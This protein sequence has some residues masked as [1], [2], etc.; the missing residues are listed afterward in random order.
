MSGSSLDGLDMAVIDIKESGYQL[1]HT[2]TTPLSTDITERLKAYNS[3]SPLEYIKLEKDFSKS[4]AQSIITFLAPLDYH[5]SLIGVHGH[6]IV[7][8]PNE[9]LTIQLGN[10]GI[11]SAMTGIDTITDFR[12]QD[13]T[14]GGEG[15]PLVSI[16]DINLFSGYDYYLNLGGIANITCTTNGNLIAYDIC[17]CN[18]VLNHLSKKYYDLPYDD[19]GKIARSGKLI[20]D[21]IKEIDSFDYWNKK[22]PKSLDNNWI[23]QEF[24]ANVDNSPSA[25]N[26]LNTMTRW[27]A[28]KIAAAITENDTSVYITGG[29]AYN[30]FLIECLET[31]TSE[32]NIDLII[33]DQKIVDY[34][35]AILMAYL[36]Y[37]RI[38]TQH[39]VLSQVTKAESNSIAGA[40]YKS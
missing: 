36:A 37:L 20:K 23:K 34:K 39:N 5:V 7:H 13:I 27:I 3:L 19:K 30:T 38:T 4:L 1:L 12:I 9:G 31:L 24:I 10:G 18:Q 8:I 14:K 33:D 15:T 6:T 17:P 28:E 29:G 35:E 25:E 22:A 2:A 40:Y 32:Q 26:Q 21:Y 11:I 16:A